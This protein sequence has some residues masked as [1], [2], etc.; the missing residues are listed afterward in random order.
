MNVAAVYWRSSDMSPDDRADLAAFLDALRDYYGIP[1][2]RPVFPP[3]SPDR[4]RRQRPPRSRHAQ[5][6]N[7]SDHPW[8]NSL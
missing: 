7:R 4:P 1:A 5:G 8:R 3:L 6:R 2:D